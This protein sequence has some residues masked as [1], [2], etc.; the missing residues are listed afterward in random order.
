MPDGYNGTTYGRYS[1]RFKTDVIEGYKI[2][3]LLWPTSD[4][5]N[6]GEIDFPEGNLD[7]NAF[8]GASAI[9]GSYNNGSMTFDP[10]QKVSTA[11]NGDEWHTATTEWTPGSVKWYWDGELVNQ[12]ENPD[13]VPDTPMRWTLQAE[14]NLEGQGVPESS[15]GHILV[16]SVTAWEYT[17]E[18]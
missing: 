15:A 6:D 10:P 5:W 18:G 12:T 17:P 16:D 14:T 11:T 4:D 2:A 13:G 1:I 7:G 8:Y 9:K 3:F